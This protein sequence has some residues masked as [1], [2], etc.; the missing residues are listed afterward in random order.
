MARLR[1]PIWSEKSV[2]DAIAAGAKKIDYQ[3]LTISVGAETDRSRCFPLDNHLNAR[4]HLL[5]GRK[6][7]EAILRDMRLHPDRP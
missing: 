1:F 5:Y 6:I 2:I 4:G 3:V 7:A